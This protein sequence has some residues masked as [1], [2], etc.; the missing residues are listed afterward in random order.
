MA[1]RAGKFDVVSEGD[2]HRRFEGQHLLGM[3]MVAELDLYLFSYAC[4]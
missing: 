1:N 2:D 4:C 3:R